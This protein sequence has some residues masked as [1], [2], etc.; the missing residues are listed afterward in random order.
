[1]SFLNQKRLARLA[2]RLAAVFALGLAPWAPAS[3][4]PA[5]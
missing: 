4:G 5:A 3:A 2:V 1:M